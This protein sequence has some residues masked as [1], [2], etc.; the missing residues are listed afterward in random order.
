MLLPCVCVSLKTNNQTK[1]D[2][3]TD[4][5][6]E[7]FVRLLSPDSL[8]VIG[9]YVTTLVLLSLSASSDLLSSFCRRFICLWFQSWARLFF[10]PFPQHTD[11]I[12]FV[13]R[14]FRNTSAFRFVC[15]SC[16]VI[17]VFSL[18]HSLVAS[19]ASRSVCVICFVN[20][21]KFANIVPRTRT[22]TALV[23]ALYAV[24]VC[25]FAHLPAS[26]ANFWMGFRFHLRDHV[27]GHRVG[28]ELGFRFFGFAFLCFVWLFWLLFDT[29]HERDRRVS[30]SVKNCFPP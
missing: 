19:I 21:Q 6:S 23:V 15:W 4:L 27:S 25:K 10:S 9:S 8:S 7:F 3:W 14:L 1:R 12:Q 24:F 28:K 5:G 22:T 11:P 18:T 13:C 30:H 20:V 2:K 17:F 26:T 29:W 16:T